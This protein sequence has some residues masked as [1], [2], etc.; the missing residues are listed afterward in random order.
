MTRRN[1]AIWAAFL[2]VVFAVSFLIGFLSGR[3]SGATTVCSMKKAERHAR[4]MF[5]GSSS[6]PKTAWARQIAL[7]RCQ[8]NR[9]DRRTVK[10]YDAKLHEAHA[11]RVAAAKQARVVS[12]WSYGKASYYID[13]SGSGNCCGY[14]SPQGVAVCGSGGGPCVPMGTKIEFSYGGRKATCVA[15]D[16][17]PYV[18]GRAF[19]LDQGCAAALGFSG[20][21]TVGYRI[22]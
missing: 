4:I 22:E 19:D 13:P 16:H 15:D 17:G 9:A 3:A 2:V 6:I 14:N 18:A 8:A 21:G 7:V 12:S 1:I 10:A 11:Q 20:V 5:S